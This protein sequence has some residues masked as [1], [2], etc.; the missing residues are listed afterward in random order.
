MAYLPQGGTITVALRKLQN[1]ITIRW[2][3]P[4]NNQFRAIAAHRFPTSAR[5]NSPRPARTVPASRTGYWCWK[6]AVNDSV[7]SWLAHGFESRR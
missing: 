1:G 4:T 7:T 6:R 5:T 3:D 2:F